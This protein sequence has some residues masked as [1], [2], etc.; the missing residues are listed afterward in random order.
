MGIFPHH[1]PNEKRALKM[2]LNFHIIG[3][4]SK[5]VFPTPP[6]PQTPT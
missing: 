6:M 2:S 4:L 1:K 5:R 3:F